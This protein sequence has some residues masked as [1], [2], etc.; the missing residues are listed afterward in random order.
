MWTGKNIIQINMDEKKELEKTIFWN[1][2]NVILL[3]LLTE[4]LVDQSSISICLSLS[5]TFVRP[6]VLTSHHIHTSSFFYCKEHN[7][8]H[9]YISI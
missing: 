2:R 7:H 5:P 9:T 6:L 8:I 3:P 4:F 1:V